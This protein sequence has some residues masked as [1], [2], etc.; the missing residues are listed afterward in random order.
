MIEFHRSALSEVRE[1]Q[2]WYKQRS[3]YVAQKFQVKLFVAIERIHADPESFPMYL[4][5]CRFARISGFPYVVVFTTLPSGTILIVAV[6]HT[7]RRKGYW[8][9]RKWKS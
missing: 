5:K 3:L 9:S 8:R 1:S 2:A 4:A 7:S 6:A